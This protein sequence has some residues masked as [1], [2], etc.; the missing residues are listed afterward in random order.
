M[1]YIL[2]SMVVMGGCAF[3]IAAWAI[4]SGRAFSEINADKNTSAVFIASADPLNE[5]YHVTEGRARIAV[6]KC[7]QDEL[8]AAESGLR[9]TYGKVAQDIKST[10]S[11]GAKV[12]LS[13]LDKSQKAFEVFRVAECQRIGD[14]ALGGSGA[15][16]FQRACEVRLTRWRIDELK[17]N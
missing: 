3:F 11:S 14:A 8:D 5:C 4:T 17:S 1:K 12:A 13:S 7:L 6:A 16:D 2:V 10:G 15:G 9:I